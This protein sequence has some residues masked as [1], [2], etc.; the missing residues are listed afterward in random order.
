MSV[1]SDSM[2]QLDV[3]AL[4]GPET[5]ARRELSNGMV[6]LARENFASPSVV[7]AGNLMAGS[8]NE[9]PEKAGLADLTASALMRGT[10]S[11]SF[12]EIYQTIESIGASLSIGAG[13]HHT[14][15]RGKALAEDLQV[16][17]DL[18]N[19]V[20]R[21]PAFPKR[22]IEQLRAE[23]LTGLALRDQD[24]SSVADM[25]FDKLLYRRHPYSQPSDGY[26]DTVG[27]LTV[28]DLRAFHKRAYGPR[29]AILAIVGAVKA[30]KALDA[31]EALFGDWSARGLDEPPEVPDAPALRKAARKNVVM[32]GKTQVDLVMG[33]AGPRRSDPDYLAA[34]LGNNVLGRFGLYGRI[35][36]RVRQQEGLAYYAYSSVSGGSGPGPWKISA[37]VNPANADRAAE[38]IK[39]EIKRFTEKK[40]AKSELT[41]NQANFIGRLPLQLESNGGVAGGLV[42]IERHGLGLDYYQKYPQSIMNI[43]REDVL[44]AARHYLDPDRL[45]LAV[46]GPRLPEA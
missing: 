19:D 9:A 15:F 36:D 2:P 34:S 1:A 8:L 4:P 6:L 43:S 25:A 29:R 12:D 3:E 21:S 5:I 11:R 10:R 27:T 44:D 41:D 7:V 45:A 33:A 13:S 17:L 28:A 31:V 18:L 24:T 42:Y 39:A 14:S 20:L 23:K 22:D 26:P 46:A 16:I 40:I 30:E 38:L 35:G 32:E 37:G